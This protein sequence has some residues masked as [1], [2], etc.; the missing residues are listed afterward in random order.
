MV[1]ELT[2]YLEIIR[3]KAKLG[4]ADESGVMS[5]LRAHIEDRVDELTEGGMTEEDALKTCLTQMG[6][7]KMIARQIYE[8]YSQGSWKQVVMASMPHL[9][10]GGLFVLNW[11][12]Y[13][14]WLSIVLVFILA[15][16]IYG[17][18]R[19][20]PTWLFPWMGY[21]LLPVLA[22]GIL[23][24]Y[25]PSGWSWLALPF[26]VPL[27][28]WWLFHV[29]VQT[30]RRD[31][32]LSTL[33]LL[34]FPIIAGWFLALSPSGKITEIN[35]VRLSHLAPWIG[36]TFLIMAGTNATFLRVRQRSLRVGLLA[37]SGM[38]TLMLVVYYSTGR[39]AVP[40]F[41]GLAVLMWG[42]F[43]TPPLVEG[44]LARKRRHSLT[45]KGKQAV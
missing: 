25:V 27:A 10:F 29:I 6:S 13:P 5:E 45:E 17:W 24:L 19:G 21:T 9:L 4:P 33:M 35:L 44:Y 3:G 39:F 1:P 42:L 2:Q 11:W 40:T 20:K 14:G 8:A 34:P 12:H 32:L 16:T 30:T 38:L 36:L 26:Y 31:W 37:A 41:L 15:T 22:A 43:L 7:T 23:L 18:S 28:L